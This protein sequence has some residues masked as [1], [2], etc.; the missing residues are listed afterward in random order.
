MR[1][2]PHKRCPDWRFQLQ[3][4]A[5][6]MT[7]CD[8]NCLAVGNKVFQQGNA[9]CLP[10]WPWR[11]GQYTSLWSAAHY[12]LV[13]LCL[14]EVKT[15]RHHSTAH[16]PPKENNSISGLF[17]YNTIHTCFCVSNVLWWLRWLWLLSVE[18]E[19]MWHYYRAIKLHRK[20]SSWV[21]G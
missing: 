20:R 11:V 1:A 13:S 18:V 5:C 9:N 12:G 16:C 4:H 3:R 14:V 6:E 15:V 8:F 2:S 10:A 17:K 7:S 21:D 19:L